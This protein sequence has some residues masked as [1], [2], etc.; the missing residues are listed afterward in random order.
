MDCLPALA[1]KCWTARLHQHL[2]QFTQGSPHQG[3]PRIKPEQ[4]LL[5]Q[6]DS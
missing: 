3:D 6:D 1:D 5:T 4:H 2:K